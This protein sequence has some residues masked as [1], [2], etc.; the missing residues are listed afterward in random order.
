MP[1]T[2]PRRSTRIAEASR[3]LLGALDVAEVA[4]ARPAPTR[5]P[6]APACVSRTTLCSRALSSPVVSWSRSS[7]SPSSV[8][9]ARSSAAA[10]R[11]S[12]L[13]IGLDQLEQLV[14]QRRA[15]VLDRRLRRRPGGPSGSASSSA[16]RLRA[17]KSS[18]KRCSAAP[19]SARTRRA[20][21]PA[22]S[23]A[24]TS[25]NRARSAPSSTDSVSS[26]SCGSGPCSATELQ[27]AGK[28]GLFFF[29]V[30]GRHTA[31][32]VRLGEQRALPSRAVRR[33]RTRPARRLRRPRGSPESSPASLL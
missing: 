5:A 13:G 15:A 27:R 16:R 18:R 9:R 22:G 11:T 4:R 2:A 32:S 31:P 1:R 17:L 19:C 3:Q 12:R 7:S 33:R 29:G 26:S 6:A 21:A 25:R 14:Q 28:V 10:Q 8:K 23:A 24:H 20:R 30:T